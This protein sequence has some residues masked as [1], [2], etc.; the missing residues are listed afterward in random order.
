M[1]PSK[2]KNI[3][4]FVL[5]QY[6]SG[7]RDFR[8]SN[9]DLRNVDLSNADLSGINLSGF[10]IRGANFSKTILKEAKLCGVKSGIAPRI[11]IVLAAFSC[12]IS[13]AACASAS[14]ASF[15]LLSLLEPDLT[16]I[17]SIS[18]FVSI[19]LIVTVVLIS[20]TWFS[21]TFSESNIFEFKA[22]LANLLAIL[23]AALGL[24]LGVFG[25][26]R[27]MVSENLGYHMPYVSNLFDQSFKYALSI[28]VLVSIGQAIIT[29]LSIIGV[30][31]YLASKA[32]PYQ[33]SIL[34]GLLGA[35]IGLLIISEKHVVIAGLMLVSPS[36]LIGWY[37]CEG[38]VGNK[39]T[40]ASTRGTGTLIACFF[41]TNFQGA[42]LTKVDF[43]ESVLEGANFSQSGS[44]NTN[45][46]EIYCKNVRGLEFAKTRNSIFSD[47]KVQKLVVNCDGQWKN[48]DGLDLTGINLQNANLQDASFVGSSLNQSNLCGVDLSRAILKQTQL[49][50]ADL[51]GAIL[52]GACIE[53]WGM[54]STTKLENVQCDYVYMRLQTLEKRNPLRKPDDEQKKFGKSEFADFIKPYFDTLDLYHRQDVDP[55]SISIALK[56]LAENHP[57]AELQFVALEW[58]GNGLNIRYTAAPDV[59]KSELNHEYFTNYARIRK[60]LLDSIQ[61]RLGAQ[62]AEIN[63]ME[64]VI[65]KFIQTGTHQSTIQ[66]ETIQMLQGEF[67]VI[68]NRGINIKAGDN[69]SISG[70]SSGDGIVN[71]G[72]ISGNV[73]NAINQL[74]DSS[75]PNQPS[76]K[77]LLAQLQQVIETDSDLPD[78]DKADLL[79]QVQSLAEAKQIEEPVKREGI[80]RKAM[81]MFDAT[82]KSLPDTARIVDACSKILPLIFKALGFAV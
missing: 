68:E 11:G 9:L 5:N 60:D 39:S 34:F 3:S 28:F 77:T 65:N 75:E 51:T 21:Q 81:K 53:D 80:A 82:L 43:S 26:M 8:E 74:S 1:T 56:N 23:M 46:A 62:D 50:G 61:L 66:A 15:L 44:I 76:L 42:N 79:E 59:D 20:I 16:F 18:K 24:A 12:L 37:C 31:S 2:A 6:K 45:L 40:W 52:T 57:D 69:A 78:P 38:A 32:I 4:Q 36:V 55:R 49:D 73:T 48:F 70:L 27:F 64:G 33:I 14:I 30:F 35:G 67:T 58:R 47:P 13:L 54:T 19:W 41:G 17:N 10:D 7:C 22:T 25:C 71:L 29:G 72:T 63:T